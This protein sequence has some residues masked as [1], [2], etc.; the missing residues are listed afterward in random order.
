M[1]VK[2]TK[3]GRFLGELGTAAGTFG[4][5]LC[6]DCGVEISVT[7]KAKGGNA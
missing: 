2:C 7:V 6:R 5:M 1:D 3:C 4:R